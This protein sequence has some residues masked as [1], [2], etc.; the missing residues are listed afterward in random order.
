MPGPLESTDS[1]ELDSIGFDEDIAPEQLW[2]E[3]QGD[4]L[5][6][7]IIGTRDEVH[8][9]DWY[10]GQNHQVEEFHTVEGLVLLNTCVDQL[11]FAMA[12]LAEPHFAELSLPMDCQEELHP[13]ITQAWQAACVTRFTTTINTVFTAEPQ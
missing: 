10:L 4:G 1:P 13:V 6:V 9:A 8:I 7:S 3:R 11:V 5:M 12:T 2:F